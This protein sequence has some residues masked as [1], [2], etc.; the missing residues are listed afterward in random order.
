MRKHVAT[1]NHAFV[2]TA[3]AKRLAWWSAG[4]EANFAGV[5]LEVVSADVALNDV[6]IADVRKTRRF[7]ATDCVAGVLVPFEDGFVVETCVRRGD[8]QSTSA[9]E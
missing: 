2:F 5:L 4:N 6:P 8:S 3:N 1:I 7:V 9:R